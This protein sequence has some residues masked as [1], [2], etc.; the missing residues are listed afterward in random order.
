MATIAHPKKAKH[1]AFCKRW[2]GNAGLIFMS[3]TQGYK[4]DPSINGKCMA[5]NQNRRSGISGCKDY[6]PSV[7][8]GRLL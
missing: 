8:A 1:C 6:E 3:S 2:N 7:E 4:F 5:S